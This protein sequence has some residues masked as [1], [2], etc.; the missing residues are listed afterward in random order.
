MRIFIAGI[1]VVAALG[2]APL[3]AADRWRKLWKVS[4]G[5][6]AMTSSIDAAS[7]WDAR[8][9][10]PVLA[11]PNGRFGARGVAIKASIAGAVA[12]SQI[13]LTRRQPA[14]APYAAAV[15]LGSSALFTWAT[16]HNVCIRRSELRRR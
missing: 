12:V 13:V 2:S 11:G 4:V 8:E 7:S 6:L 3:S 16:V 14:A 1:L 15:N 9:A 10:N 5:V